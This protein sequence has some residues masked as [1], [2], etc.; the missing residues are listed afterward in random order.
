MNLSNNAC[1]TLD[2]AQALADAIPKSNIQTL[3]IGPE[4]T[5]V[6][7]HESD[8]MTDAT[9]LASLILNFASNIRP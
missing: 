9:S 7:V 4:A 6:P 1:L 8:G 2:S 3:V 5:M